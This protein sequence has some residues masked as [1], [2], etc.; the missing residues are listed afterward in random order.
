MCESTDEYVDVYVGFQHLKFYWRVCGDRT[1]KLRDVAEFVES[2]LPVKVTSM[3]TN[4]GKRKR[5]R[6]RHNSSILLEG[7]VFV[8][9][10][11]H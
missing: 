4:E 10:R 2:K 1:P 5:R 11:Q 8:G 3:A 7:E 9:K 6:K